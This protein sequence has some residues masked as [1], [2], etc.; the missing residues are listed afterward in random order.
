LSGSVENMMISDNL[1]NLSGIYPQY[2]I[3]P[4]DDM[5]RQMGNVT[6]QNN[7][8]VLSGQVGTFLRI[9]GNSPIGALTVENNLFSA[10]N[11]QIGND[12]ST[13]VFI[14]GS[15]SNAVKLFSN[16]VWAAPATTLV[17]SNPTAVNYI[18]PPNV[19]DDNYYLSE[20]LWGTLS[21]VHG[22]EFELVTINPS[23]GKL[24]VAINGQMAGAVLPAHP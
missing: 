3:I 24:Q 18:A 9:E 4:T 16:N 11:I 15:N 2:Q 5:G 21:N 13:S 1:T 10:P 8:G 19:L 22:D 12:I 6:M 17:T 7:T 20:A 14:A 23:S